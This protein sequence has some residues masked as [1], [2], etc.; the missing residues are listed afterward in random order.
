MVRKVMLIAAVLVMVLAFG[1]AGVL[2]SGDSNTCAPIY[3]AD[4]DVW[5]SAYYCDGRLNAF[6]IDQPFAVYYDYETVTR[7]TLRE[8]AD[9]AEYWEDTPVSVISAIEIW[10]IDAD[11]AGHPVLT[12]PASAVEAAKS[13]GVDTVLGS[14]A[15]ITVNYSAS[16]HLWA[17][18]PNGYTFTWAAW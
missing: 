1:A 13:A 8:N 2:A 16:G 9:G 10:S 14:A 7:P 12:I 6:D 4:E 15:G 18:G 3:N 5:V 11:S 17:T